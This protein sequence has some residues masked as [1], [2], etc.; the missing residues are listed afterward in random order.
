MK[1]FFFKYLTL[2]LDKVSSRSVIQLDGDSLPQKMPIRS[3]VIVAEDDEI[4][5]A[6]LKCP[7]GCGYTI[8]LP[9]IREAK[10]RWDV[11]INSDN[12]ISLYPSVFLKK[13]CKS[14]F[15]IKNGKIIWCE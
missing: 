7:C 4:W 12:L 15:W 9:I 3:I 14:H 6:G 11:N 13:G 5:C 8:E 1:Q 10:P 2:F